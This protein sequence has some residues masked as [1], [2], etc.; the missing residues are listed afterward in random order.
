[1]KQIR[2]SNFEQRFEFT[3]TKGTRFGYQIRCSLKT[4]ILLS[5]KD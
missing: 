1:M 2:R 3:Q 5:N 4:C